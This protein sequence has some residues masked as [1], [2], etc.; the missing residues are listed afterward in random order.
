MGVIDPEQREELESIIRDLEEENT[1]LQ[2]EYDRLKTK[3][4]PTTT[5]DDN[6]PP[7]QGQG[8]VRFNLRASD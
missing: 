6:T 3:Q 7:A 2:A 4:T 8:G 1:T 5:P